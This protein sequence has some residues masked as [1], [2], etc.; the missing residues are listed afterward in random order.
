[1]A[2][3]EWKMRSLDEW[4]SGL[5]MLEGASLWILKS[6]RE[7]ARGMLESASDPGPNLHGL[8]IT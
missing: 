5:R 8:G 6:P 2:E 4:E 7:V 1:M 3:V